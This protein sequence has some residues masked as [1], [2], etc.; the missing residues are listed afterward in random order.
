LF[1]LH[2]FSQEAVRKNYEFAAVVSR[3]AVEAV[4]CW[5]GAMGRSLFDPKECVAFAARCVEL[6]QCEVDPVDRKIW[7]GIAKGWLALAGEIVGPPGI[8]AAQVNER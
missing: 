6:A 1:D 2:Q 7:A 8:P 4:V 3:A 5:R